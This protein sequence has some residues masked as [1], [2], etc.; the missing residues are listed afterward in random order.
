MDK[1]FLTVLIYSTA[2]ILVLGG[3]FFAADYKF[4]DCKKVG[5]TTAY[6][7]MDLK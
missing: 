1:S 4:K 2:I 3:A 7:I 5:H 6:C